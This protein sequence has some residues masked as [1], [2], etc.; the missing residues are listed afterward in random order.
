MPEPPPL[1]RQ[2][3][4]I[5]ESGQKFQPYHC[6]ITVLHLSLNGARPYA[7]KQIRR[8][9]GAAMTREI[10]HLAEVQSSMLLAERTV[11]VASGSEGEG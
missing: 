4:Q 3:R 5:P 1:L 9:A 7:R 11:Y 2:S 10:P 8:S 6:G